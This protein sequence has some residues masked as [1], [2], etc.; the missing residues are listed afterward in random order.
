MIRARPEVVGFAMFTALACVCLSLSATAGDTASYV[1]KHGKA[2]VLFDGSAPAT[3]DS[4]LEG[5]GLNSDPD[6]VFKFE[7]GVI[8]VSGTEMGYLITKQDLCRLLP[9]RRVQVG[10]GDVRSA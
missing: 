6:H 1:P 10:R 2:V 8:H 5:K 7:D 9:A 3:F 4:F